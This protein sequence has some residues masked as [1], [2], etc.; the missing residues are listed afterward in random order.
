MN[1]KQEL[2]ALFNDTASKPI[3][4]HIISLVDNFY[5]EREYLL[6]PN[7]TEQ[8][9]TDFLDSLDFEYDDGYG[10]Q[11]LYGYVWFDDGSW[12]ERKEYDGAECWVLKQC[13]PL[14]SRSKANE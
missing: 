2:L 8:E 10:H 7:Y 5:E 3:A 14:P 6:Y 13:P 1:A 11:Y 12:A 9:Y 4:V